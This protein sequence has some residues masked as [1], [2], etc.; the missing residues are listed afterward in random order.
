[1][2]VY[3]TFSLFVL[4]ILSFIFSCC[5]IYTII[6]T[7]KNKQNLNT[8]AV[9]KRFWKEGKYNFDL[10]ECLPLLKSA[11]INQIQTKKIN[12]QFS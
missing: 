6:H 1:M 3:L 10:L 8:N 5:I 11:L 12:R 7:N 9:G 4:R 2:C